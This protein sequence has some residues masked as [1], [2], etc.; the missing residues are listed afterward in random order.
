KSAVMAYQSGKNLVPNGV[1][2]ETQAELLVQES[3]ST[4]SIQALAQPGNGGMANPSK[5]QQIALKELS[6]YNGKIDGQIGPGTRRSIRAYQTAS[7]MVATG[8]LTPDEVEDLAQRASAN[9]RQK[10]DGVGRQFALLSQRQL[11]TLNGR[12]APNPHG[13][14]LAAPKPLVP[15][16][17]SREALTALAT[18][19]NNSFV[20]QSASV[21]SGLP[22][23]EAV[24]S[25]APVKRPLDVAVI[26]GNRDYK[27]ADIP[28]VDYGHRDADAM[29][30]LLVNKL[31]FASDNIIDARDAGQAELVSIFGKKDNNRGKIWRLI[32]P[33]GGSNIYVFYSGH[34]A[35][36]VSSKTPY[37]MP[38]D[39]QTDTIELNGYPLEQ[40]Y[41]NL[42]SLKVKTAT[43]FLDACFSGGSQGGML[44]K[45]MSPVAVTAK[46]PS[47]DR[48][49][50]TVLAAAEG[51][52]VAS[53]NTKA[54]FGMFTEH[55]IEGLRGKADNTG[56]GKVTAR[57]LHKYVHDKVRRTARRTFGRVQT[58]V[59]MGDADRVLN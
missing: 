59:L 13:Q 51:D 9:A 2:D 21:G 26:I 23:V 56:D 7:G 34:G 5:R 33:D 12:A 20:V 46:M 14:P 31:G 47:A 1:L 50:L 15:T 44:G 37:L 57:E 42:N 8:V 45:S 55:L 54:G 36:E 19:K 22:P 43:V 41:D 39:A 58:P 17:T 10:L 4:K 52:Q 11:A 49:K 16:T 48:K 3:Q 18:P 53:W 30:A 29:K 28:D 38:V 24:K 35:P 40:M 6:Y 27:G 25:D 32:D